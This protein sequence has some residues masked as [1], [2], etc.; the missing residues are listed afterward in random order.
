VFVSGASA[1]ETFIKANAELTNIYMWMNANKLMIN[2]SKTNYMLFRPSS[3]SNF[4]TNLTLESGNQVIERV[5]Q[6]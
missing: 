4:T 2:K 3:K 5:S 6:T 1:K